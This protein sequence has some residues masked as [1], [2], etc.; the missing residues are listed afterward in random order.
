MEHPIPANTNEGIADKLKATQPWLRFIG[1]IMM[2]GTAFL[3]L[4]TVVLIGVS[5]FTKASEDSEPEKLGMVLAIGVLYLVLAAVYLYPGLL[6]LRS[7][8]NIRQLAASN[9]PQ[10]AVDAL[11]SQRKF[12]KFVGIVTI[13]MLALYALIIA[14]AILLPGLQALSQG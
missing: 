4:G 8:R 14:A 11:E 6:L 2:I 3:V 10:S 5:L 7:A 12:W 1:I 9:D 13:V